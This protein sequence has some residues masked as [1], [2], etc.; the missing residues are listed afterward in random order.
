MGGYG[1]WV[2]GGHHPEHFAAIAPIVGGIGRK[3]P[4]DV[5]PDLD[6]WAANLAKV[7]VYAFAGAKDRVVPAERSERMVAAI[8]KAG[9][10]RAKIKIYPE[11]G[12]GAS[13]TVFSSAEYFDW[14]FS[15]RRSSPTARKPI[16]AEEADVADELARMLVKYPAADANRDGKLTEDEAGDYILRTF[17][18]KRPNRGPG[19]RDRSLIDVYEART[20]RTMPYRLMKPIRLEAG[21]RYPLVISLHGSGGIGDDNLSNLRFWNGVMAQPKWR[22]EYACFVLVPQ[23]KPGGYWGPKPEDGRVADFYVRNDLLPVF[24]LIDQIKQECPIDESRIYAL[25]SSGGGVGTW[26]IVRAR[27]DL[28]AAAIPVCGRFPA[29]GSDVAKLAAVP[30]WCF[31]GDA[32]PLVDVESSRRAFAELT[33][34]GGLMKYTELRGVKHNSWLQA[35]TYDGDDASK[36]Y[37]TR[38]SSDRCDRTQDA[39]Q[40]LFRQRRP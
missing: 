13:K 29:Q 19:I 17:Q 5:T 36:G 35:F 33:E 4:K 14:M 21:R 16:P 23:R 1:C 11:E 3:G 26:N 9:G 40:W 31:H 20:Y 6:Q 12:H 32:D 15:Q 39:W 30:I 8:R 34:A 18:R 7:P 2:W 37:V 38:Y 24:G 22:E 28:F 10:T 25:G 27:P